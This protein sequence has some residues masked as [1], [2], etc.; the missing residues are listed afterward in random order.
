MN[1][2]II[3]LWTALA[4]CFGAF[5]QDA[6]NYQVPPKEIA[7]LLLAKTNARCKHRQS[8]RMDVAE[9]T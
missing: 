1:K 9:R 6:V 8:R 3:F 7:D 4:M 2:T 5:A